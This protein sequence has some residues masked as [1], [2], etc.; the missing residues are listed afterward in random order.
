MKRFGLAIFFFCLVSII[1]H[2][3]LGI[4]LD[5]N[6]FAT[7]SVNWKSIKSKHC[8]I[9][10]H[11]EVNLVRVNKKI[12]IR[13]YD[14][15]DGSRYASKGKSIEEQ[16]ADKIDR[17]FRKAEKIL[18]MYPRKMNLK[19]QIYKNQ[20]QLEQ[21]YLKAFN[22]SKKH[23]VISFYMHKFSTIYTTER[24]ISS[25]VLAHEMGHA[26]TDHYFLVHPPLPIKE[27]MAQFV[28]THLED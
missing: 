6:G 12:A 18:D 7:E 17:I 28:E 2:A 1:C 25:D 26:I 8:T 15:F 9:L 3:P 16:V 19:I 23:K 4:S 13:F 27:L 10:C 21:E 20:A 11:P 14:A 22:Q 24:A 5:E